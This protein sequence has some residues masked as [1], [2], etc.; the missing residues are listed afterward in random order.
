MPI[1]YS[2]SENSL[3]TASKVYKATV[4]PVQNIQEDDIYERMSKSGSTLSKGEIQACMQ[5]Y[6]H[7]LEEYL[8]EG[9]YVNTRLGNYRPGI[10]GNFDS[11]SENFTPAKH[12]KHV[13]ISANSGMEEA[14][15][16]AHVERVAADVVA[17]QPTELLDSKSNTL[18]SKLTP[19][20]M[21]R[22]TGTRLQFNAADNAEGIFFIAADNTETRVTD[23][24]D[25][26]NTRVSFLVPASLTSG[27]YQ[28]EVRAAYTQNNEIRT[29]V[30]PAVLTVS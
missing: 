28:L 18:N 14:I 30:L 2:L 9:C 17:P 20:N 16:E 12:R 7:T 29:G 23:I 27:S 3:V 15:Q 21:A 11:P 5:L 25:S 10:K 1:K 26:T 24:L 6:H 22:L 8:K 19:A 4:H 13:S